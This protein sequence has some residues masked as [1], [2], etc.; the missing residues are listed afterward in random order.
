MKHQ[1]HNIILHIIYII[2][3]IKK[4]RGKRNRNF[5]GKAGNYAYFM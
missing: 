1:K 4:M 2:L 3:N 5:G